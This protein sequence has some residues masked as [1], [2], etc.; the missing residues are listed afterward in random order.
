M[1]IIKILQYVFLGILQGFTEPIPI[2]SSGHLLIAK[3]LFNFKMLSDMNFEIVVN[4]GSFLAIVFLYRKEIIK[5]ISHFFGYLKTKKNEYKENYKYAWLIVIGTIPAGLFGI[6]FKDKIDLLS[7]NVKLV[8]IA[9]LITA[10]ALFLIKDFKGKKDK[11]DLSVM[12]AITVGLFQVVA[13]F[14][15]ISRSGSC[16]SGAMVRKI[17]KE[18]AANYAFMLFVPAVIGAFVLELGNNSLIFTLNS[19][20]ISCYLASFLVSMVATFYAFKIL[21]NFIIKGKLFYF[22]IYCLVIGIITFVYSSMNGWI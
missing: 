12:D 21:L 20:M 6:I 8:G 2:S 7:N 5:I 16:I 10:L 17:E 15:G 4:F 1:N 13:L 19:K 11:K 22:S 18:E 9:L 3:K 14:P